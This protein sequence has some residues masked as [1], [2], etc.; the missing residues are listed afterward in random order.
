[1]FGFQESQH[2]F[3]I[4]LSKGICDNWGW[5]V[6]C[7]AHLSCARKEK[8]SF[9]STVVD[10]GL[11]LW[12]VVFCEG[13]MPIRREYRNTGIFCRW[14]LSQI[15]ESRIF[16]VKT[17]MNRGKRQFVGVTGGHTYYNAWARNDKQLNWHEQDESGRSGDRWSRLSYLR[18]GLG[19]AVGQILP[20]E[21]EEGTS[22]IPRL[23][24]LYK[25]M[26]RL[27]ILMPP[28][29][30]NFLWSKLSQI[31]PKLQNSQKF[32]SAKDSRYTIRQ[33][34]DL[35]CFLTLINQLWRKRI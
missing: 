16:V 7:Q 3:C 1:M 31:P 18:G 28:Y 10:H 35:C 4:L 19:A 8:E 11:L 30:T 15:A 5:V 25:V 32:L 24:P 13:D 27:L 2:T 17:F 33:T 26:T 34:E 21:W 6:L 22:L 29:W 12:R 20:C 23:S 14:I 9:L